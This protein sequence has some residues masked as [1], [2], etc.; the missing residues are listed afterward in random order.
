M[1]RT[2]TTVDVSKI[3]KKYIHRPLSSDGYALYPRIDGYK[4]SDDYEGEEVAYK[5]QKFM[6]QSKHYYN[7]PTNIRR[8]FITGHKV[9]VHYYANIRTKS[10]N[11]K[12][13]FKTTSSGSDENLFEI[14]KS[15]LEYNIEWSKYLMEKNINPK[16]TEPTKYSITKNVMNA[17]SGT[18]VCNNLE[19]IY[20][21]WTLFLS[22]DLAPYF[23]EYYT[24]NAIAAFLSGNI[25]GQEIINNKMI[26]TFIQFN[27]GGVK[28]LRNRFPRLKIVG[29]IS[30]LD[31]LIQGNPNIR[32]TPSS[33]FVDSMK[34]KEIVEKNHAT[35]YIK[36]R[37]QI[38][39]S[40]AFVLLSD[41]SKDLPKFNTNFIVKD[42]FYKY[43][44]EIL[45]KEVEVYKTN[46]EDY[47][48][49]QRYGG[50]EGTSDTQENAMT[51]KEIEMSEME[52]YLVNIENQYGEKVLKNAI[53]YT[54]LGS[55]LTVKDLREVFK[56]FTKPNRKRMAKMAGVEIQ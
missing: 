7:S 52:S 55:G 1:A 11:T 37:E 2:K 47:K 48:R 23:G 38:L 27:M 31:R 33:I 56:D 21:D 29:M 44:F 9:Y 25:Q 15:M 32:M 46:I 16:A 19:E 28:K 12:F 40:G 18:W 30:N 51:E 45:K 53:M 43:D 54:A 24:N 5:S 35:W 4:K 3:A 39:N 6:E 41:I 49:K 8:I 13:S 10:G 42:N 22:P 26:E 50:T 34:I 17:A 36:N 20:F 14:A